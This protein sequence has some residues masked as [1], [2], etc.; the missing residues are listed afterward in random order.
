MSNKPVDLVPLGSIWDLP[1]DR[2]YGP[3]WPMIFNKVKH[4]FQ[5]AEL[6]VTGR[7]PN[8]ERTEI[9]YPGDYD[10]D[11]AAAASARPS[12]YC[13]VFARR[14]EYWREPG[15]PKLSAD[16]YED[17]AVD[18][19][20]WDRL[21]EA[22]AKIGLIKRPE[23]SSSGFIETKVPVYFGKE[24]YRPI[25]ASRLAEC[26]AAIKKENRTVPYRSYLPEEAFIPE[27][28]I[29][30]MKAA[31]SLAFDDAEFL[32]YVL[33]ERFVAELGAELLG[34]KKSCPEIAHELDR[35]VHEH[36]CGNIV[37]I[38][39][40][41][42]VSEWRNQSRNPELKRGEICNRYDPIPRD[43]FRFNDW[44]FGW[45]DPFG[46]TA[47]GSDPFSAEW[48]YPAVA[49]SDV[50]RLQAEGRGSQTATPETHSGMADRR[51]AGTRQAEASLPKY[52]L[53][54]DV[55]LE[56]IPDGARF[57][58]S[59]HYLGVWISAVQHEWEEGNVD[60]LRRV[61]GQEQP[62][63]IAS[64]GRNITIDLD[65]RNRSIRCVISSDHSF[66][67]DQFDDPYVTAQH[68]NY[69]KRKYGSANW[70]DTLVTPAKSRPGP[71]PKLLNSIIKNMLDDLR[72]GRETLEGLQILKLEALSAQYGGSKNTA[73]KA[74]KQ[75]LARF[76]EF[77]N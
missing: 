36:T 40:R 23:D 74:R 37:I 38:G 69:L 66:D 1:G 19:D 24:I 33:E 6:R 50:E 32:N 4:L 63:R 54:S 3:T 72:S 75:A 51:T 55:L 53:V 13:Q 35:L 52:K 41:R 71:K 26:L 7:R 28:Y 57:S 21:V 48:F 42:A 10:L 59:E 20:E 9:K 27:G 22:L 5:T 56:L 29:P 58:D 49:R 65:D 31:S 47:L 45:L 43:Y 76:S 44:S 30:I 34:E 16:R 62:T 11:W 70:V 67:G 73:N 17:L 15:N 39:R 68:I 18:R 14:L 12:V 77:Q 64:H 60:M 8:G 2:D 61:P 25:P 46:V